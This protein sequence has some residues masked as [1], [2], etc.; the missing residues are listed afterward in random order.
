MWKKR[1]LLF[2]FLVYALFLAGCISGSGKEENLCTVTVAIHCDTAVANGMTEEENWKGILPEDGCILPDTQVEIPEGTTVFEVLIKVRD[3]CGIQMEYSGGK[4]MEYIEGIGHLY[5]FDG[6]R[7]SGWM[8]R[9]NGEY[10][11]VGCGKYTVR[12]GDV[13]CWDYTCDL[14]LDLDAGME[15]AQEWKETHE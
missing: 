14:G 8:F 10:P 11:D 9:V 2:S 5:E 13:I 1:F 12:D 15:G 4:G 7:W 6:G 3:T